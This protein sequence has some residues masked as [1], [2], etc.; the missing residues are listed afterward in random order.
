MGKS[1]LASFHIDSLQI[2]NPDGQLVGDLPKALRPDKIRDLYKQMLICREFDRKSINLQRQGRMG[3]YA[4]IEG[5]EAC[6]VGSA[7]AMN[8]EDWVF[9]AFR[10]QAVFLSRGIPMHAVFL[11]FMGSEEGNRVPEGVNVFPISVCVATQIPIATG[12]AMG[13]QKKKKPGVVVAYFSDGATSEGDFSEGLNFAS[14]FQTPNLFICQNNQWAIS[15]P[16]AKQTGSQTLAQ[17]ALAYDM[18]CMQVDGNDLLAVYQATQEAL[19]RARSGNGPTLLELVTYRL[20]MHSTADDPKKYRSDE[21]VAEWKKKDPLLR[22]DRY[23]QGEGAIKADFAEGVRQET[24]PILKREFEEAERIMN[25]QDPESIF[26]YTY[27]SM[28]D[29]LKEQMEAMNAYLKSRE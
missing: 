17:K 26:R 7:A 21:E 27:A 13:L 8:Q 1:E 23:L 4:P 20:Q 14:V 5:Q 22:I 2:L 6:Q 3:T 24:E 18:P 15:T 11:Y 29:H 16:R 28:P 25:A 19:E 10:E 12:F 9:P